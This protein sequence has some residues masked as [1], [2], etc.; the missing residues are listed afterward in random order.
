MH[1]PET[2]DITGISF[3]Q[4]VRFVFA[5]DLPATAKAEPWYWHVEVI[6]EAREIADHYVRLFTE[7]AFPAYQFLDRGTR[8]GVLCNSKP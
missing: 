2:Q 8:A 6:F 7:P 5:R 1:E 4:F 3:E